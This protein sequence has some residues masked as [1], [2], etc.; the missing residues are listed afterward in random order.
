MKTKYYEYDFEKQLADH[1]QKSFESEIENTVEN[2]LNYLESSY[3]VK[4]KTLEEKTLDIYD[5]ILLI[6]EHIGSY[7]A[8]SMV[9]CETLANVVLEINEDIESSIF[10]SIHGQY[11]PANALLR[12]WLENTVNALY[13][14]ER[15]KKH[16]GRKKYENFIDKGWEWLTRP[17]H[18]NF[19]GKGNGS[20]LGTLVDLETD[21]IAK[22]LLNDKSYFNQ[23]SSFREYIEDLYK[24]LSKSVH[25]NGMKQSPDDFKSEFSVYNRE[26]FEKWFLN[27]N[28]INEIC[29]ILILLKFPELI[30][31][32]K[33][34]KIT[35]PKLEADQMIKL[36]EL[37]K[38][39]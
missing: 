11:N 7:S 39:R 27:F 35:Y 37:I 14:D 36:D 31:L 15:L 17:S 4:K 9:G 33:E 24:I 22:Q 34:H 20:S 19:K 3:N 2:Y 30:D 10:L 38:I 1:Y 28:Q 21:N 8:F 6:E 25:F 26:L 13:F 23:S 32:Y 16:Y 5:S 29:N 18:I 12:K